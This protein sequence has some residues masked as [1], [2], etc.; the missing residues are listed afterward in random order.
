MND[1]IAPL[2]FLYDRCASRNRR[3]LD[4][5]LIGCHTYV[6]RMGWALA[7]LGPWRD[8]GP[9]A[10]ST[11]RPELT[12]MTEA[13]RQEAG[14]RE[15]LCLVHTWGRLATD[16]THRLVLQQRIIE[17]GGYTLTTF[18]ESDRHSLRAVLVG[19]GA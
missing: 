10:L 1:A 6:D 12:A 19:R 11:H 5:R 8:L 15:V 9:D 7:A 3:D 16:D 13:M 17:A 18:G 14:S 2:V 4:M